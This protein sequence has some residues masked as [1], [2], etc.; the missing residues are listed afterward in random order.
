MI[1]TTRNET[2][3]KR[4]YNLIDYVYFAGRQFPS[5]YGQCTV[6]FM[7]S[8]L[9]ITLLSTIWYFVPI[10]LPSFITAYLFPV[11]IY[12]CV[13]VA[14]WWFFDN[15]DRG[16]EVLKHFS[17]TKY[18]HWFWYIPTVLLTTII[19][20]ALMMFVLSRLYD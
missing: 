19:P 20:T 11:T 18:R 14:T 10:K 13:L 7:L 16:A 3:R 12:I 4:K 15:S 9:I 17:K 8:P 1:R 5:R 6:S 2:K